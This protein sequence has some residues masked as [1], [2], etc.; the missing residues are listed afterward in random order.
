MYCKNLLISF[1]ILSLISSCSFTM[2]PGIQ[3][4]GVSSSE[5][6][7]VGSFDRVKMD[8]TSDATITFGNEHSVTVTADDNLLSI[9]E[10]NVVGNELR[11]GTSGSYSTSIGIDI[12]IVMPALV[13]CNLDGTGD[14]N[15][16]GYQG[17]RL[18]LLT[19]G[20]GDIKV[21]G[22]VGIVHATTDGTG[23]INLERLIAREAYATTDG[24]GD[25]TVNATEKVDARIDGT[26]DITIL[27]KPK[28]VQTS[29]DGIGDIIRD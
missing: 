17:E 5:Q 16:S 18:D 8:G 3:G 10:T 26:G 2:T 7:P 24:V 11:I 28:D 12:D 23:D 14:L 20:T 19:D 27:G 15:V 4:S 29:I 22:T 1:C 6:R 21:Q 13:A 25:I 9:I